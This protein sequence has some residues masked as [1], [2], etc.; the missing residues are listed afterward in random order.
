MGYPVTLCFTA[1]EAGEYAFRVYVANGGATAN[2]THTTA[3][4]DAYVFHTA[5]ILDYCSPIWVPYGALPTEGISRMQKA[6][7]HYLPIGD[8]RPSEFHGAFSWCVNKRPKPGERLNNAVMLPYCAPLGG[9]KLDVTGLQVRTPYAQ[10]D[11]EIGMVC[12]R[13]AHPTRHGERA[14]YYAELNLVSRS[15]SPLNCFLGVGMLHQSWGDSQN[16]FDLNGVGIAPYRWNLRGGIFNANNTEIAANAW[17]STP[18]SK[19]GVLLDY[20][21]NTVSFYL[22]G[23]LQASAVSLVTAFQHQK[24]AF[25]LCVYSAIARGAFPGHFT[26]D[27]NLAGPFGG[28]KPTGAYAWDWP[29]EVQ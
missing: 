12:S 28:R 26:Y 15:G 17:P 4:L 9:G 1:Q 29:N 16:S 10:Q 24:H 19:I 21:N 22:D 27:M 23:T 13:L 5:L 2:L 3:N 11:Q 7:L 8:G 25:M 20:R 6:P 14:A 18:G